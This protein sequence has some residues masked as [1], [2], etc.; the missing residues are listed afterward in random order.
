MQPEAG[1]TVEGSWWLE[2][3][4]VCYGVD[5]GS[6]CSVLNETVFAA[7]PFLYFARTDERGLAQHP[8]AVIVSRQNGRQFEP[9][10]LH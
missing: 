4:Q 9:S 5:Q 7:T 2:D 1:R 10:T 3:N 8:T 6:V